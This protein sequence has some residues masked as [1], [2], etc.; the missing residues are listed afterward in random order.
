M[1]RLGPGSLRDYMNNDWIAAFLSAH[2]KPTDREFISHRWLLE[3]GPKRLMFD[4]VYGDIFRSEAP[5]SILDV[6]GGFSALSRELVRNHHYQ[7]LEINAHDSSERLKAEERDL[8]KAFWIDDDWLSFEPQQ[9]YDLVVANDLFPN[10]DQRLGLFLEKYL[11]VTRSIRLSLTYYNTP[12][13]YKTRR[14]D[15]GQ[16]MLFMLAWDGEQTTRVLQS[17][18][19]R[20]TEPRLELL[21]ASDDS[22]F[23]N[24]RQVCVIDLRGDRS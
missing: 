14:V 18:V 20:I 22:L 7:L 3:S 16:E 11:R 17:Y 23:D 4:V 10:V 6:G 5:R 15:G 12:R 13:F 8:G 19:D 21:Q 2:E 9:P 1:Q 24:A